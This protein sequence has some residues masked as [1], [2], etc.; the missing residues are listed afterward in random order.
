MRA[1]P[2]VSRYIFQ[3][4][5]STLAPASNSEDVRSFIHCFVKRVERLRIFIYRDRIELFNCFV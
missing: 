4:G 3:D 1:V 5:E 2:F